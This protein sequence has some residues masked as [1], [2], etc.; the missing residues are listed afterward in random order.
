MIRD[1]RL[2]DAEAQDG[3]PELDL[4]AI[5]EHDAL[6][7]DRAPADGGAATTS[8]IRD[9]IV[10]STAFDDRVEPGDLLVLEA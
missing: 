8:E 1:L 9:Q 4:V 7:L 6:H 5:F 2:E 10:V 3:L